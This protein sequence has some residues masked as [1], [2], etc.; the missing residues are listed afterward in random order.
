MQFLL[1]TTI[2]IDFLRGDRKIAQYLQDLPLPTISIVTEAEIYQGAKNKNDLIQ[3]E[4]F[5]TRF[6]ILP[7]TSEISRLGINLLKKYRL[8][9]GL[10]ILDAL[11][12]ATSLV[13]H[14]TIITA[15]IKDFHYVEG[16]K[17]LSWPIK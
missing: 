15:N 5:L 3:W 16:L 10:H 4:K 2:L 13:H 9:H 14:L 6:N 8:S 1:D 11:I 12:I 17:I 7:I